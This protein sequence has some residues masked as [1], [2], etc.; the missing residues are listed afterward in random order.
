MHGPLDGVRRASVF[1]ISGV[2]VVL[3]PD[4]ALARDHTVVQPGNVPISQYGIGVKD[5]TGTCAVY[6]P[7][8]PVALG[9]TVSFAVQAM[10]SSGGGVWLGWVNVGL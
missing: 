5:S 9:Q 7:S 3:P 2:R 8:A 10:A 6:M 4:S 1:K